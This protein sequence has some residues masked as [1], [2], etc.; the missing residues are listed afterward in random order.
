MGMGYSGCHAATISSESLAELCPETWGR[1][2]ADLDRLDRQLDDFAMCVAWGSFGSSWDELTVEVLTRAWEAVQ[3]EFAEVTRV[4]NS[5]LT[6]SLK[7]HDS[8]NG[9]RYDEVSGGFFEVD[10][11]KQ[12]SPAGE[13]FKDRIQ[14]VSWAEYG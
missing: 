8:D 3:E 12:L 4:G 1:F 6:V 11:H 10:G 5:H 7:Y 9:S 13:R 2:Q 14:E